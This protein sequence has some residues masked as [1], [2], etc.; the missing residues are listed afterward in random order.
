MREAAAFTVAYDV[1][2]DGERSHVDRVLRGF[3]FRVQKSVFECNLTRG[4]KRALIDQLRRLDLKTGT[5]KIYRIYAGSNN[6]VIGQP[7]AEPD[8]DYAYIL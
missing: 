3:G 4:D 2:D 7:Q 1:S 6:V 5:V 8:E